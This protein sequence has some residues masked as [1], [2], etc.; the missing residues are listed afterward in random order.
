[1]QGSPR[2]ASTGPAAA[3]GQ[4]TLFQIAL[5]LVIAGVLAMLFLDRADRTAAYTESVALRLFER[6]IANR[7]MEMRVAM[8]AGEAEFRPE[9]LI[10]ANPVGT[11]IDSLEGYAGVQDPVDW[12]GVAPGQWVFVPSAR[13][14][15]YR[16]VHE[17]FFES[18]LPGV[19]RVRYQLVPRFADAN[20][21]GE[22]DAGSE[23]LYG[24]ELAPK[25]P[26]SWKING[27]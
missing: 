8:L 16:V 12:A 14:L 20:G 10:G 13:A 27:Q 5:F 21:N 23:R 18:P 4:M 9:R 25:E 2:P 15:V 24:V 11:V 26:F 7:L 17:R 1:M 3:R 19:P 6:Q 22:Y